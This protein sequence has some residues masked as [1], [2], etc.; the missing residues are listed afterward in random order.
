MIDEKTIKMFDGIIEINKKIILNKE[1]F[2]P[3]CV[4]VEKGHK[5]SMVVMPFSDS[6]SKNASR[7]M[8][9]KLVLSKQ[10]I[11]YMLGMDTRMTMMDTKNK[12]NVV[13]KDALVHS[14]F[15]PNDRFVKVM[16]YDEK[17]GKRFVETER[18]EDSGQHNSNWDVWNPHADE[19]VDDIEKAY[20]RYKQD[21][22]DKYGDVI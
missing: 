20:A 5:L 10:T 15:S 22:P 2:S 4:I 7:E 11:A 14:I 18:T 9:K 17:D 6:K 3:M 16:I 12:S 21:N 8:L 13:V 19:D 1:H